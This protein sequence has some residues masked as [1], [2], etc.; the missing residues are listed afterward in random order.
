M[1]DWKNIQVYK[2]TTIE[3]VIEV[4]EKGGVRGA[5]VTD[6]EF[7]LEG[8]VTDGDIR[9]GIIRGIHLK[10]EVHQIM[11][12]SP[13]SITEEKESLAKKIMNEKGVLQLPMI[14]QHGKI[15]KI[16]LHESI[17]ENEKLANSVVIMAGGL[18]TRLGVLTKDTPKPLLRVGKKPILQTIVEGLRESGFSKVFLSVNY[19]SDHIKN[20]FKNGEDFSMEISYLNETKKLGTAGSLSLL[21]HE[22]DEPII[23]MN[24]DLLTKINYVELLDYHKQNNAMA[25]MCVREYDFQVPYGVVEMNGIGIKSIKEKPIHRF[26]VNAGVYVL[27]PSVFKSINSDT[28]VDMTTVFNKLIEEKQ[29]TAVFPIR[30]YWIDIGQLDDFK[31]ANNEFDENF[32]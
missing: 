24:G 23:V 2:N 29:K 14:D 21:P 7:H 26:F 6:T 15:L 25:T 17:L 16:L 3:K 32:E 31:R 1:K 30:E 4:I 27:E 13:I 5:I 12:S 11:N 10:S 8:T 28:Y 18:G 9:R 22:I 20:F 19:K